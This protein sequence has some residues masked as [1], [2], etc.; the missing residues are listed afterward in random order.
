MD[1]FVRHVDVFVLHVNVFFLYVDMV[2]LPEPLLLET[3]GM[4][5]PKI[6]S[7]L[8]ISK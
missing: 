7:R 6:G 5:L 2:F 3:T 1:V 4:Y 8:L